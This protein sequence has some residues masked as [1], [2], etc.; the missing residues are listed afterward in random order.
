MNKEFKQDTN[1]ERC[2]DED[3]ILI[4]EFSQKSL[5]KDDVFVFSVVLC[6]NEVDRDFEKFE[7][8]HH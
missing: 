6:D 1:V 5:K 4:N 2:S 3:L 8:F 7:K